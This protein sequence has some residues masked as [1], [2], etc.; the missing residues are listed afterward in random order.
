MIIP[1]RIASAQDLSFF[2]PKEISSL[3]ANVPDPKSFFGFEIG[4]QH[5]TYDAT[6][7]YLRLLASFSDRVRIIENGLTY[8]RKPLVFLIISS[9]ENIKNIEKIRAEHINLC[10]PDLSEKIDISR[11]PVIN[12]LGYSIHGN[13]ASGINASVVVSYL[14]SAS[15]DDYI[16]KILDNNVIIIQPALNPDGV[17]KYATWVNSN[18]SYT[19]NSDQFI[20]S[21]KEPAPTSRSN[22]YWFDLNRDWLFVQHPE[23]IHRMEVFYNW[24]PTV[25]NDYHEHGN[26]SGSFFSPGIITST[27]S[28]IPL[29]NQELC[30]KISQYHANSLD[31]IGTLYFSKEGYDD[32]YIG[33]GATIPDIFGGIGILYEQPNSRGLVSERNGTEIRFTKMI[34]NQIACSFSTLNAATELKEELLTYQKNFFKEVS[35]KIKKSDVKGYIFGTKKD[36]STLNEF[37]KVLHTHDIEVYTIRDNFNSA[38]NLY[39]KENS[40]MIPFNHMNYN[41]LNAIFERTENYTD[42]VFYDISSWNIPMAMNINYDELKNVSS[43]KGEKIEKT[44]N[45][46]KSPERRC[47]YAYMFGINDF[48]SYHFIYY[49]QNNG[50]KLKVSDISFN[51][52]MGNSFKKFERGT[53]MLSVAEQSC[54]SEKIFDLICKYKETLTPEANLEVYALNQGIGEEIDLGSP[55]FKRISIPKIALLT[56][57][58]ATYSS[59]GELWHLLDWRFRIPVSVINYKSIPEMDLTRYNV[60]IISNSMNIPKEI[61]EKLLEWAKDNTIIA[62]GTAYRTVNDISVSNITTTPVRTGNRGGENGT[63][64][65]YQQR[66]D[67]SPFSGVILKAVID[68]THPISFGTYSAKMPVFY[69]AST[70]VNA[71]DKKYITPLRFDKKPH[72][73]GYVTSAS[74]SKIE[75]TPYV[76]AGKGL[77]YFAEDPCFRGYWLGTA[78]LFLN[79]VF[80]RELM[81]REK[82]AT[83]K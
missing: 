27:N 10:N 12:W 51:I 47:D 68:T 25:V 74:L 35:E 48:Y 73:S 36:K 63:F 79:S 24:L 80:F 17:Q 8:E 75:E 66:N 58:G 34:R 15:K 32:F 13:E 45:T 33:K 11:M 43:L 56:G 3:D 6:I 23:S 44:T 78:R 40:F 57:D 59:A 83:K 20:L 55:H 14:L 72:L 30:K 29:K 76:F 1:D 22:H 31:Q 71:P 52:K 65:E 19:E 7:N 61:C 60:I 37:I 9:A 69:N 41:I 54:S 26:T 16:K 64:S 67:I 50:I 62:T 21:N 82:V 49:L 2:Y 77:I 5:L 70:I 18:Y 81:P 53:V 39:E 28:L 46:F 38:N 42:S 4:E